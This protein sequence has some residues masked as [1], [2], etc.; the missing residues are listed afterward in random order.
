MQI[1]TDGLEAWRR[2][3]FDTIERMLDP[4]VEWRWFRPGEWDCHDRDQVMR[5]LRQRHAHGFANGR[6]EFRSGGQD[7]V[8]VVSYPS[9]IGG[10]E[11]PDET[12][13]VMKFRGEKVVSM[14]DYRT[15]AEALDAVKHG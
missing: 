2:G 8:I 14:Q 4:D 11:W 13:T 3:D 5:T 15:E 6:L 12:A 7:S 10:P 1:A 9:E